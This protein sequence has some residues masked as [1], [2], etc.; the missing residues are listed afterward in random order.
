MFE[1]CDVNAINSVGP[2]SNREFLERYAKSGC[3]GL[4][5]GETLVDRAIR[6]AARHVCDGK[7]SDWSHAFVFGER[8]SD[9]QIWVIES[10]L[11]AVRKHI[12]F[13]VQ[14]K[15]LSKFYDEQLYGSM[16]VLDFTL[17]DDK[18][19]ALIAEGLELVANATR[20][21][22][23]ELFGTL[24]GLRHQQLRGREN[25]LSREKSLYC[26]AM[27][28]HLFAKLG[29]ELCPGVNLKRGTPEDIFR[30]PVPHATFLLDRNL[31]GSKLQAFA[32]RLRGR[33]K[34]I[35]KFAAIGPIGLSLIAGRCLKTDG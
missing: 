24:V 9:G 1:F 26:S 18:I 23:R 27:V 6:M 10:D 4:A 29:I 21:T 28:Q 15:R 30:T 32:N 2:M 16:A 14:E 25:V 31:Q 34:R 13:G 17:P 20:Y 12:R 7:W 8:R 5:G 3:I 19:R 33:V 22:V 35:R 11:Q